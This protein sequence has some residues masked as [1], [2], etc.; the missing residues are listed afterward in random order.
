M[1]P[2][3]DQHNYFHTPQCA[4]VHVRKSILLKIGISRRHPYRL[5]LTFDA[6]FG[7]ARAQQLLTLISHCKFNVTLFLLKLVLSNIVMI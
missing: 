2:S 6:L 3:I 5:F 7:P 4:C 1:G